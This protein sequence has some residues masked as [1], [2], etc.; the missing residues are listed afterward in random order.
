MSYFCIPVFASCKLHKKGRKQLKKKKLKVNKEVKPLPDDDA[1]Y[2]SMQDR[3][4]TQEK[5][6]EEMG[7]KRI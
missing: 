5:K 6:I 3:V 7:R 2:G 1:V 4:S